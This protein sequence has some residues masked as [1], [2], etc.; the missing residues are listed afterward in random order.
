MKILNS[1][2]LKIIALVSM[3]IDHFGV[4]FFPDMF[5]F[6]IIGRISLVLYAFMLVEG[7][8]HTKN[9]KKYILKIFVWAFISEIPFDLAMSGYIFNWQS[10]N[11]FFTLF[12][13]LTGIYSL[14]SIRNVIFKPLSVIFFL[15]ASVILRVDY[16][17]YGVLLIFTFYY[18]KN[19]EPL[20]F[21][22]AEAL[23]MLASFKILLIQFFAFIGF[24]P[25]LMYNG[26]QGKKMGNF[27]YS[28]YALHLLTF[29]VI[30]NLI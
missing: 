11:I 26:E 16:S 7:F 10:Q 18:F 29:A 13:G 14:K 21:L 20:K 25:I 19:K 15:S 12:L 30:K 17:W 8:F 24:I 22:T 9:F 6:R 27:Y 1:Y 28:F 23:S 3:V 4:V 5:T 2:H